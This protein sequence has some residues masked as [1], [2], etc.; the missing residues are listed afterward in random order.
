MSKQLF[1]EAL[2]DVK[3]M[4]EIAEDNAKKALIEAV[5]PRIKDLIESEL[6]REV[7]EDKSE[8]SDDLLLD[9]GDSVQPAV[10]DLDS[11]MM[12]EPKHSISNEPVV[13]QLDQPA[14]EISGDHNMEEIEV[15][16]KLFR[17][18]RAIEN[19]S[20][21]EESKD[22]YQKV[23][24][25]ISEVEGLYDYLQESAGHLQDKGV[26]EE[27]LE[28]FYQQL[29]KLVEQE[30]MKNTTKSL[31]EAEVLLRLKNVP[32]ELEGQLADLEVEMEP[33]DS[34][35]DEENE[36]AE[37]TDLDLAGE[38]EGSE[39][40]A[41]EEG[42][43]DQME[44]YALDDNAVVEIDEGMLRREI[45]RMKA[46]REA[47]ETKP[48][49]WGHGPGE[50]SSEED[51]EADDLG[52]PIVDVDLTSESFGLE[53]GD[54][55]ELNLS[56]LNMEEVDKMDS[57]E[58]EVG[59]A[60]KGDDG[61]LE[62][63]MSQAVDSRS[64]G[65]NVAGEKN[66]GALPQKQRRQPESLQRE[67][68]IQLEARKKAHKAKAKST[69]AAK[70]AKLSHAKAV[71]A[72]KKGK[73]QEVAKLRKEATELQKKAVQGSKEY[74]HYANI[75]NESVR[76]ADK[77]QAMLAE[78]NK[79]TETNHNGVSSRSTDETAS[80][81]KKLAETNLF[82][83]KLLYSNK[84]LQNESL[85][86]RQKAEVIERLD[87]ASSER[88]VKLVYESLIKALSGT[89]RSISEGAQRKV[90]GSSSQATRPA[91]TT[92]SEGYEADRWAKLAGLK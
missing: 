26:Y 32:D 63:V 22:S 44:A 73:H 47:D 60:Q 37:A 43:E 70:D 20:S 28:H 59:H 25:L 18:A 84:L 72:A 11:T 35:S 36:E 53:E 88:E 13:D 77:L 79:R 58:A 2:A 64:S 6:L 90:L 17:L 14:I 29:N 21:M 46:L 39:E 51:F 40:E 34:E 42:D 74:A 66:P 56:E 48:Q 68:A 30:N 10:L 55:L 92:I 27:K 1:E 91:A 23:S 5:S 54:L 8:A 57:N 82:N 71:M 3:K 80:L 61:D 62:E 67:Q 87:E 50:V 38:E 86:K 81:R 49:S 15:E 85:T 52:D 75:F 78:S 76:R 33:V 16:S 12:I 24:S 4:K 45:A 9:L 83:M 7:E 41:D 19:A 65:G 31:T 69:R 89:S